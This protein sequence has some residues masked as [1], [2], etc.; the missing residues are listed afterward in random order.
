MNNYLMHHGI[1]G[2][3][4]GEKNGPPYPLKAEQHSVVEITRNNIR[5][6]SSGSVTKHKIP[7]SVVE[8][9]V[10]KRHISNEERSDY[11]NNMIKR[12]EKKDPEKAKFYKTASIS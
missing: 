6:G 8:V 5:V 10:N 4:W 3:K 1:K 9:P 11:R 7:R 2:Q 12:Y